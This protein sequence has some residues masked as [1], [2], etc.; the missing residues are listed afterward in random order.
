[1]EIGDDQLHDGQAALPLRV[2]GEL[3][4]MLQPFANQA[5]IFTLARLCFVRAQIEV[6][7]IECDND[8]PE[9]RCLR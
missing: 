8:L 1:V 5:V 7:P 4:A 9:G 3:S 6:T 2:R